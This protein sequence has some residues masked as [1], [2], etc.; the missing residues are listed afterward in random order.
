MMKRFRE[1]AFGALVLVAVACS[2]HRSEVAALDLPDEC[3]SFLS[4]FDRCLLR[5]G[6][7]NPQ[8]AHARTQQTRDSL[9]AR[10]QRTSQHETDSVRVECT[11]NLRSLSATCR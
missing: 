6:P 7:G 8:V 3:E 10:L 11:N 5:L 9:R 4:S 2:G 1:L